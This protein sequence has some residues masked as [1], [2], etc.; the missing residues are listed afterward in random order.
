MPATI[1][2]SAA[3]STVQGPASGDTVSGAS[4][5]TQTI[6]PLANSDEYMRQIL[7]VTGV[8]KV[9]GLSLV[10][11]AGPAPTPLSGIEAFV[12]V[13][14]TNKSIWVYDPTATDAAAANVCVVPSS[15]GGRWLNTSATL[16]PGQRFRTA[17][18]VYVPIPIT[19]HQNAF[20]P[21]GGGGPA[22]NATDYVYRDNLSGAQA[23][24]LIGIEATTSGAQSRG[25]VFRVRLPRG[26][27]A[28]ASLVYRPN[29]TGAAPNTG[30]ITRPLLVRVFEM[31]RIS[32]VSA[33]PLST[34]TGGM[35][36]DPAGA[37]LKWTGNCGAVGNNAVT[38]FFVDNDGVRA[39]HNL[40]PGL[41]NMAS[42]TASA[43][44]LGTGGT[45][46]FNVSGSA[47][48]LI[49]VLPPAL[50]GASWYVSGSAIPVLFR[51]DVWID[52]TDQ[53]AG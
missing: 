4:L 35:A 27:F 26:S 52:I 36:F 43:N 50:S 11:M 7:E 15:G 37:L 45:A 32:S 38:P 3:Y 24:A 46:A 12:A 33:A 53:G 49:H 20:D 28:G 23:N 48:Y 14:T 30:A 1:T 19:L 9:Q 42:G 47:E 29:T 18:R 13:D 17:Q 10:S 5:I 34:Y 8:K 16:I 51:L 22:V 21:G 31:P 39:F 25:Y 41:I 2:R 44:M 6:Q 40:N